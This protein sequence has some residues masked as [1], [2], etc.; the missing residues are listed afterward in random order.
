MAKP[1]SPRE[2]TARVKAV[3]RAAGAM[4]AVR[5]EETRRRLPAGLSQ[6][7]ALR[8]RRA[9]PARGRPRVT[10]IGDHR[11][12]RGR[13]PRRGRLG[14]V[15]APRVPAGGG[16]APGR[17]VPDRHARPALV[18]LQSAGGGHATAWP[19]WGAITVAAY[20]YFFAVILDYTHPVGLGTVCYA[21]ALA[22]LVAG[23]YV[24]RRPATAP[25]LTVASTVRP[26]PT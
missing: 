1:F 6:R 10:G 5:P 9:L 3:L 18:C 11:P 4:S 16:R 22:A 13:T 20:P 7:G 12:G 8:P 2:L 25:P 21:A 26:W 17:P 14:A 23:H 15:A 19:W 24:D